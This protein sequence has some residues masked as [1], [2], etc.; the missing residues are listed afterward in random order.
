MTNS[1]KFHVSII[2]RNGSRISMICIILITGISLQSLSSADIR[3]QNH[4]EI[5]ET[6]YTEHLP[7][8]INSPSDFTSLGF[9]GN[10]T[11]QNP[12]RIEGLNITSPDN[13]I[14][15]VLIQIESITSYFVINNNLLNGRQITNFGISLNNAYNGNVTNNIVTN[16]IEAAIHLY[17]SQNNYV[18]SNSVSGNSQF[19]SINLLESTENYVLSNTAYSNE[20]NGFVLE[21]S[22]SNIVSDNIAYGNSISGIHL[23]SS[24]SFNYIHGNSLY[25]NQIQGIFA[26]DFCNNNTISENIVH[27][28]GE[29]GIVLA[30]SSDNIL[31]SNLSHNNG[32]S[33]LSLENSINNTVTD[34]IGYQNQ[35][36]EIQ[37]INSSYS[38]INNNEVFTNFGAAGIYVVESSR[39][40]TIIRNYVHNNDF[41]MRFEAF[42]DNNLIDD[43][44]VTNNNNG[45]H[46]EASSS[47]II[48]ENTFYANENGLA[49]PIGDQRGLTSSCLI[50]SNLFSNN[51][52]GLE[53]SSETSENIVRRNDFVIPFVSDEPQATD[54]GVNNIFEM[55]YWSEWTNSTPYELSGSAENSDTT[56]NLEYNHLKV[57]EILIQSEEILSGS[58]NLSWNPSIDLLNHSLAYSLFYTI[59]GFN[60]NWTLISNS[61]KNNSYYWDTSDVGDGFGVDVI[62]QVE[63]E[64]GSRVNFTSSRYYVGYKDTTIPTI[65]AISDTTIREGATGHKLQWNAADD[66]PWIYQINMDGELVVVKAP[67]VS[68]LIVFPLDFLSNGTH[69]IDITIYDISGNT[70]SD[71]VDV[72]VLEKKSPGFRIGT[73]SINLALLMLFPLVL[74][75]RRKRHNKN[76]T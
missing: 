53:L 69:T 49:S 16:T 61:T 46:V 58:V 27:D 39:N 33:G 25:Q 67:W 41:G 36:A 31:T 1:T 19:G 65:N 66:H 30:G 8:Y 34:N 35:F 17:Q 28:N 72:F 75:R 6:T 26:V 32:N 59:N 47:L 5:K 52:V 56:P 38:T 21:N 48:R 64:F 10:G 45:L 74:A 12:Y 9:P 2:F 24:S 20:G 76:T 3:N 51:L 18:I 7:I 40:N 73:M 13:P 62:L 55:N 11:L 57:N 4:L 29:S 44:I 14:P 43:N 15:D 68:G 42:S 71:S 63:D 60:D 22:S 50:E 37:L 70:A 23:T 54:D